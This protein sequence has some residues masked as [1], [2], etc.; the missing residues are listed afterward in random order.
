ME[1][2][3]RL[4]RGEERAFEELVQQYGVKVRRFVAKLAGPAHA[5]DLT[6]EVFLRVY[7]NIRAYRENGS[8]SAW[9]FTIANNLCIDHLRR[10]A[11]V[12][13]I[14][15][16]LPTRVP[17]PADHAQLAEISSELRRAVNRLPLEQK[18]VFLLREEAGLPFREIA[19]VVGAPLGTVLA[20]MKYAM[21]RLREMLRVNV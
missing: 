15:E 5:D 1:F 18:Q 4:Q 11:R 10:C 13:S 21:D 7:R 2:V 3:R 8:F 19:R 16:D 6:Q 12:E 14:P 9:I 20:R 17:G